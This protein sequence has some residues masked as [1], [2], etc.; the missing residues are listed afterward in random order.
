[1][2]PKRRGLGSKLQKSSTSAV[3]A[4]LDARQL[5]ATGHQDMAQAQATGAILQEV[6]LDLIDRSPYQPRHHIDPQALTELAASIRV[7][8]L[9]Q[10][11]VL[12][13]A[14]PDRYELIAGERRWRAAQQAD[15]A[16]IPAIV[17][18]VPDESAIAMA[19]IENMQRED[20]NAMEEATALQRIA[21]EFGLTHTELAQAVGKSR[22][23]VSNLLRLNRLPAPL[24]TML[25]D[26]RLEMGH[27]RALLS[28]EGPAQL[29]AAHNILARQLSVRQTEEHVRRLQKT[30]Q[31]KPA[32]SKP[33]DLLHL[34]REIS[35]KLG[36]P[37]SLHP[38]RGGKGTLVIR[39]ASLEI[40]DGIL[41][42][43]R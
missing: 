1:M 4:L 8:G 7:Q 14:G 24:R 36:T 35:E 40:L 31:R 19:L 15:L 30:P 39:Y 17:R 37:V 20:L 28:L 25:E 43:L 32:Q 5:M 26:G 18:E 29:S 41:K 13:P 10:P 2:A 22:S 3:D 21:D 34:E 42:H 9:L 12:R 23:A 11:I 33:A 38:T 27:A 6:P 16:S